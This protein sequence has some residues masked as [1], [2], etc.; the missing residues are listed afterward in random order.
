MGES[1]TV[2][3]MATMRMVMVAVW[4]TAAGILS[5]VW[6]MATG[7]DTLVAVWSGAMVIL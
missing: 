6:S 5:T 2:L 7:E 3:S 4:P 1:Q